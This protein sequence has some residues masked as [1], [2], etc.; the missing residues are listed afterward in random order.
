MPQAYNMP[1]KALA[2]IA[3]DAKD[4]GIETGPPAVAP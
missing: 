4:L 1:M 2:L 3:H